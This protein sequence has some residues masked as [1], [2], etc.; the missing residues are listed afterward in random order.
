MPYQ[1]ASTYA[2]ARSVP[3]FLQRGGTATGD[4]ASIAQTLAFPIRHGA[5]GALVA[6]DAGATVSVRR[7]DGTFLANAQTATIASSVATYDLAAPATTEPLGAGWDVWI[8]PTF[9]TV[10]YPAFRLSA[11]MCE[12]VPTCPISVLD[13]YG[14]DGL[15]ELRY[16]VPQAQTTDRGDGTGWQA[17]IDAAYFAFL[18]RLIDDGQKPWLVREVTG[19]REYVLA[20]ALHACVMAISHGPDSSWT[21]ISR[22]LSQRV[23]LAEGRLRFQYTD[24]SSNI[25]RA[26]VPL[27]SLAPVGRPVY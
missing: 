11:Y 23:R 25:R 10:V 4:P 22:D 18:Q 20:K 19:A 16:R 1:G 8:S 2:L 21:D 15:P 17:Q 6:P 3:F 13:I 27:I 12:W 26:G 9:S 5:T 14:G 7:P 24:E